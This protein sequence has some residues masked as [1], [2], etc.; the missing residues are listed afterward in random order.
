MDPQHWFSLR[1]FWVRL[2]HSAVFVSV[3]ST[4]L[5][6]DPGRHQNGTVTKKNNCY[7]V[8][9]GMDSDPHEMSLDPKYCLLLVFFY[10]RSQCD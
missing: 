8:D 10:C 3:W 9:Q 5:D 1:G 2:S 7:Y 4:D 6:P